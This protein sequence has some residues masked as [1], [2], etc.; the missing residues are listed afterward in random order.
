MNEIRCN[1]PNLEKNEI[2]IEY[3]DNEWGIPSYDDKYLFEMIL[4]E[5]FHCGLSWLIILKK[6]ES[7]RKAFDNFDPCLIKDY[8]EVKVDELMENKDI[9]R[10]KSKILANIENAKSFLKVQKEFG[11]FCDYI[12][13][14]TDNKILLGNL[15]K[16]IATNDLSDTVSKDLKKRGFKFMG[17]VTTY[18]YLEAIGVM[19]NHSSNCFRNHGKY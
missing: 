15:D 6:R 1:W 7:F 17:S 2:Y 12:W 4:L 3:H 13:S 11:S 19:N 16:K 8:T 5:S 14:F 10:N 18:S 9:I